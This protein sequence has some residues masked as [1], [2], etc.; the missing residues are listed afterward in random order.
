MS[1]LE[2]HDTDE[3]F[4]KQ[5]EDRQA[6]IRNARDKEREGEFMSLGPHERGRRRIIC[7]RVSRQHPLRH[8]TG[9]VLRIPFLAFADESIEDSDAVLLPLI[10]Q[11][12]KEMA[13]GYG[14]KPV[15][16]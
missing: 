7:M 4:F 5:H 2:L 15:V 13:A 3:L 6:M 8:A 10:H 11:I 1:R 14:M 12:M 16:V 9:K